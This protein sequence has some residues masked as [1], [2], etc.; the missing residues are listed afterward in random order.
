VALVDGVLK[1][2]L[3]ARGGGV[4]LAVVFVG[5][6]G[7]LLAHGLVGLFVGSIHVADGR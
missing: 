5:A 6:I 4:P 3:M 2:Y 7:G 1:P